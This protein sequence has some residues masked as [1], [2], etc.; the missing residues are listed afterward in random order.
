[1]SVCWIPGTEVTDTCKLPGGCWEFNPGPLEE[2][3]VL[4]TTGCCFSRA[5]AP[6]HWLFFFLL[7][8]PVLLV[9]ITSPSGAQIRS[10][11]ISGSPE[12][13]TVLCRWQGAMWQGWPGTSETCLLPELFLHSCWFGVIETPPRRAGEPVGKGTCW[14][15]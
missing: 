7:V 3:L 14:Q 1:M 9:F 12:P 15:T 6:T 8:S 4:L 13:K 10:Q 11:H 5:I 2:Q